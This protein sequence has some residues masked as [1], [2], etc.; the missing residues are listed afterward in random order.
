MFSLLNAQIDQGSDP[1]KMCKILDSLSVFFDSVRQPVAG[2]FYLL[3]GEGFRNKIFPG[4]GHRIAFAV[5][6]PV[7]VQFRDGR[8]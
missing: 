1:A 2:P 3:E 4:V 6:Q 8:G 7:G 5:R